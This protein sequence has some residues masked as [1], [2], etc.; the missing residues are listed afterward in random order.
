MVRVELREPN[1]TDARAIVVADE[2]GI[3]ITGPDPSAIDPNLSV[4]GLP[5][6]RVLRSADESPEEW[7]RGLV[8]TY[9]SPD[10]LALIV[11]DD[12]PMRRPDETAIRI[13]PRV[14]A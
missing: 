1:A 8:F 9:R 6:G 2:S 3:Q 7:T 4:V 13:R 11:H 12:N 10:L 5:S 14:G